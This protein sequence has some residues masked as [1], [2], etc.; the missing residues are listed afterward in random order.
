MQTKPRWLSRKQLECKG[1]PRSS[2]PRVLVD[3][4]FNGWAVRVMELT[5]AM[6]SSSRCVWF[7]GGLDY[8]GRDL[9]SSYPTL[10][11]KS[12]FFSWPF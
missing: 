9:L 1:L 7:C 10:F 4:F 12:S 5:C 11:L 2:L 3:F 6:A 8:E